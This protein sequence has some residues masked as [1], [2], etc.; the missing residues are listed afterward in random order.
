M[1][2]LG[3]GT[4][5]A[6]ATSRPV[7]AGLGIAGWVIV[8]STRASKTRDEERDPSLRAAQAVL[9]RIRESPAG[10]S[11]LLIGV[12]TQVH[13]LYDSAVG[14]ARRREELARAAGTLPGVLDGDLVRIDAQLS[15]I[16]AALERALAKVV[17]ATVAASADD[18]LEGSLESLARELES[19]DRAVDEVWIRTKRLE[20]R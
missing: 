16:D 10:M 17:R 13:A 19:L 15:A 20:E 8:S 14:L 5:T 11:D 12:E 2:L 1:V 4:V 3:A 18:T 6:R 9:R 7:L